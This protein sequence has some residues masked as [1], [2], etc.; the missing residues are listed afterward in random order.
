MRNVLNMLRLPLLLLGAAWIVLAFRVP[1]EP[2]EY[3]EFEG[4]TL[5][6]FWVA[7]LGAATLALGIGWVRG[8]RRTALLASGLVLATAAQLTATHPS[9]LQFLDARLWRLQE[10]PLLLAAWGVIGLQVLFAGRF[11]TLHRA[12]IRD[13]LRPFGRPSFI[14]AGVAIYVACAVHYTRAFDAAEHR[15]DVGAM[16]EV[17]FQFLVTSVLVATNLLHLAALAASMPAGDL[18]AAQRELRHYVSL[19]GGELPPTA[20]DRVLPWLLAAFAFGASALFAWRALDRVPHV[21]DE[22][23]YLFQAQCLAAGSLVA[24]IP[25]V[26][27]AFEVYLVDFA[28]GGMF[29][30]TNPGWP[31]VLALGALVGLEWLVNP[32]LGA[33]AVLCAHAFVRRVADRGSAHAVALLLAASPWFLWLSASFMTHALTLALCAGGWLLVAQRRPQA[34]FLGGAALGALCLVRPLE[35][36]VVGALTGVWTLCRRDDGER[37]SPLAHVPLYALGCIAG[38]S[39]LLLYNAALGGDAFAFP[40]NAYLDRIWYP[41]ANALGFG[42]NV[43]NPPG[44]HVQDP[45]P[46]HGVWDALYNANQN[47]YNL[48][49]ELFGWCSGSL[50]LGAVHLLAGRWS[51]L[52]RAAL[53][54]VAAIVAANV[55][56]WFSG[57]SDYGARYWYLVILPLA[58]LSLR[59]LGTLG[60]LLE[61]RFEEAT[62]RVAATAGILVAISLAVFTPWRAVAK[63][64][65]YRG[66]H[67]DFRRLAEM[68]SLAGTLVLVDVEDETEYGLAFLLNDPRGPGEGPVFAWRRDDATEARLR[69]AFPER[70]IVHVSGRSGATPARITGR[71]VRAR[72]PR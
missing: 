3:L 19:P 44:W 58:W 14:A 30:V 33:L 2:P 59:G 69:A 9:W 31:F 37:R 53:A 65:D 29:G 7:S 27:E 48:N 18:G 5:E 32:L 23:A 61:E 34:A 68:P 8:W 20:L 46:G 17:L 55:P 24:P 56:Y 49:F 35:G 62:L 40:I 28:G 72:P 43:G 64:T 70:P 12:T 47:L 1:V 54:F 50:V 38:A 66:Y 67:G 21:P 45:L 39:L 11:A 6:G 15:L 52:D 57:G 22:V 26:P 16:A 42:P 36:V 10:D 51:R 41:G 25:A 71:E 63:Y 13:A 4:R 60:A